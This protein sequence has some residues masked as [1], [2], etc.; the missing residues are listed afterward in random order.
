MKTRE[1]DAMRALDHIKA[2]QCSCQFVFQANTDVRHTGRREILPNYGFFKQLQV[3]AK[4]QYNPKPTDRSWKRRFM[5]EVTRYLGYLDDVG[6]IIEDRLCMMRCATTAL[7]SERHDGTD[8]FDR[9]LKRVPG[10]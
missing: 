9:V 1:W 3:Y 4:C 8:V 6:T 10:G 2:R 7:A 5:Q